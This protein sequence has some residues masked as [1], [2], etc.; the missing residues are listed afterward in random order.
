TT[1]AAWEEKFLVT[2]YYDMPPG[3]SNPSHYW[4]ISEE[5]Q[6]PGADG[7]IIKSYFYGGASGTMVTNTIA[8][9]ENNDVLQFNYRLGE[10]SPPFNAPAVG[11]GDF[12]V[13]I[14]ID[15]GNNFTEIT[16]VPN[17]G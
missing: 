8:G 17:N 16:T 11:S 5:E 3:W 12:V 15:G 9:V 10:D 7:N 1:V 4:V 6:L 2:Y 14:S 13:A